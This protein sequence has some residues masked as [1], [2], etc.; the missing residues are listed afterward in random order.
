M[1]MRKQT[2]NKKGKRHDMNE[3][4]KAGYCKKGRQE[5]DEKEKAGYCKKGKR[6]EMF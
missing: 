6:Q 2:L 3:K 4:E 1:R 5:M